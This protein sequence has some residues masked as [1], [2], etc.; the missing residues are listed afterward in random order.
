MP[1][2]PGLDQLLITELAHYERAQKIRKSKPLPL[3]LEFSD[4]EVNK[5]AVKLS[6]WL[7]LGPDRI[8]RVSL[9]TS[10]FRAVAVRR[11]HG[12][13]ALGLYPPKA[14]PQRG[15]AK[16]GLPEGAFWDTQVILERRDN[17][18]ESVSHP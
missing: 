8:G 9:G 7:C 17:R 1:D 4:P 2:F 3:P 11:C 10:A 12:S 6:S 18:L 5:I 13:I 16:N 15:G 14:V